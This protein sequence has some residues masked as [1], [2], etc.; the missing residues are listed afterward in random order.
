MHDGGGNPSAPL[1]ALDSPVQPE[2]SGAPDARPSAETGPPPEGKR[3]KR[4][5]LLNLFNLINFQ[6]GVI[7]VRFLRPGTEDSVYLRAHPLPCSGETLTCRWT[8]GVPPA[9]KLETYRFESLLVSDG[10]SHIT[11]KAEVVE[12]D[13]QGIVVRMPLS[14]NE[15]SVR[16]MDRYACEDVEARLTQSGMSY[17]GSLEDFN[18]ISLGVKIKSGQKT[19]YNWLN[20]DQT[21]TVM[22]YRKGVLFYSGECRITRM[23]KTGAERR[24]ALA[25]S[26]CNIQRYRPR[27]VRCQRQELSPPPIV[28]FSHPLTGRPLFLNAEDVSGMGV[29]VEEFFEQASLIPGMLIEDL[30]VELAGSFLLG[31]RAQVLYTNIVQKPDGHRAAR[32][33]IVFLD[34]DAQ[35]QVRLSS[36]V[37]SSI[38]GRLSVCGRV[39]MDELWRFFFESGFIYPSKYLSIHAYKEEFTRT[40][41]KLYLESPSIA[42]HFFFRDKGQIFGHMSMLRYYPDSWIIHHHAASRSG[43]G[44]AGVSVLDEAG[45]FT[46][47]FHLQPSTH[48]D[49]LMCYYRPDN[50]FPRRVF[51][52]VVQDIADRKGSSLDTFAYLKL[53]VQE[54]SREEFQLFPARDGDIEELSGRYEEASGGLMIDGLAL[55]CSEQ[56]DAELTAEYLQQGFRR[57]RRLYSLRNRGRLTAI[58]QVTVSDLGLNLSNLTNCM[59]VFVLEPETLS[60]SAL[61]AALNALRGHYPNEDPPVLVYPED[62]LDRHSIPYEKKYILWVLDT[63]YSDGYFDSVRNTFRRSSSGQEDSRRE[64]G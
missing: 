37:H 27:R 1:V 2:A 45:R 29:C 16:S 61:F 22:L 56:T 64:T 42:R 21:V 18:T 41:R 62:Y 60:P 20:P 28:R 55:A 24:V 23:D 15:T 17:E 44:L 10:R 59:Q 11:V 43:Y 33:G 7:F 47:D 54:E 49:Y 40:Y 3:I 58:V 26:L 31:C 19:A 51:G 39:E 53:P 38:E 14:G 25:P 52:N 30:S 9:S 32:S 57:E 4:K 36:A 50:R 46:N 63:C 48:M 5:D 13:A 35:A 12:L 34:L 8:A 6:E